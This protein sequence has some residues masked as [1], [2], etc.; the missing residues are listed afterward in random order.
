[1]TL[2]DQL[3]AEW[4]DALADL[5]DVIDGIERELVGVTINPKRDVIF[6][7]LE[8]PISSTRIVVIGQDP[9]PNPE[10]ATGWAFSIP[11]GIRPLPGSL[12]N[13]AREI[14]TDLDLPNYHPIDGDLTPW[15]EQGVVLLN[16]HLTTV[17]GKSLGHR[18][19]VNIDWTPITDRIVHRLL[20]E[21]PLFILWDRALNNYQQ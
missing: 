9:Y 21:S 8:R 18:N 10:Y 3:T 12:R 17:T 7:A 2:F 4:R 1:M 16:R 6:R 11:K 14:S 13:I 5:R 15:V 20:Q 19:V